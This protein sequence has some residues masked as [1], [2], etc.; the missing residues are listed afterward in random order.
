MVFV[1]DESGSIGVPHFERMKQLAIDVTSSFEIAPDRTRVGWVSFNGTAW[2]VFG[3][4]DYENEQ[5]LHNSINGITFSGGFTA[6]GEGLNVLR[7]YGF[8]GA[9]DRF[10][11]AEVAIVVTDG[12]TNRGVNTSYAAE[13]L[14]ADRDVNVFAVGIG[15]GVNDVELN[16]VASAGIQNDPTQNVYHIN[17]FEKLTNLQQIISSKTCSGE[18]L[19]HHSILLFYCIY[20]I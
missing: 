14:R 9:R 17:D 7:L 4:T 1:M 13:L 11:I 20:C 18:S 16:T 6:I 10:D 2:V 8:E 12:R 19:I 3:L 5:D 15:S